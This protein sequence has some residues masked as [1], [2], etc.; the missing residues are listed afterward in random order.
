[1]PPRPKSPCNYWEEG[2]GSGAGP[3]GITQA[4]PRVLTGHLEG[5]RLEAEEPGAVGLALARQFRAGKREVV[6]AAEVLTME[7][8]PVPL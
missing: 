4:E 2:C 5:L 7:I 6:V 1:M 3:L 8:D